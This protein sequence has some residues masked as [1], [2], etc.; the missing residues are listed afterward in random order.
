[1]IRVNHIYPRTI[2]DNIENIPWHLF[3]L[4]A[5]LINKL[6]DNHI[7]EPYYL[8]IQLKKGDWKCSLY[9]WRDYA[10]SY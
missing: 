1:M 5:P 3:Y 7:F 2:N 6:H 8:S 10:I 4:E 9:D